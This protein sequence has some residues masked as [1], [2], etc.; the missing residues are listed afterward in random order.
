MFFGQD[1]QDH[2]EYGPLL[3]HTLV[4]LPYYYERYLLALE[5]GGGVGV[6]CKHNS[7][8]CRV[9]PCSA[10]GIALSEWLGNRNMFTVS[11]TLSGSSVWNARLSIRT[12]TACEIH[13]ALYLNFCALF[14]HTI[15]ISDHAFSL[16]REVIVLQILGRL[17]I[18][19]NLQIRQREIC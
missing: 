13:G 12:A 19:L 7:V 18:L 1:Q 14:M 10:S 15:S 6:P 5:E 3:Q 16:V 2:E 8:Q 9:P 4:C 11:P 17:D